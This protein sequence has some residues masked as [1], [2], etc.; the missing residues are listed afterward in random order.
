MLCL[1]YEWEL[2]GGQGA[3]CSSV[4]LEF[5]SSLIRDFKLFQKFSEIW[6][7]QGSVIAARGLAVNWFLGGDKNCNVYSLFCIFHYYHY[8]SISMYFIVLLNCLY[9][10]S[11]VSPFVRLSSPSH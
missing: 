9:L 1:V 8:F 3:F 4:F 10:N 6:D 2:A 11:Q 5:E 7:F